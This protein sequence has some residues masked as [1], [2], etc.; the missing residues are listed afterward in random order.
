[1]IIWELLN[2]CRSFFVLFVRVP[3]DRTWSWWT[4][5]FSAG[6]RSGC[7]SAGGCADSA[8]NTGGHCVAASAAPALSANRTPRSTPPPL[9]QLLRGPSSSR[10]ERMNQTSGSGSLSSTT[11][12]NLVPT[13][14]REPT[15]LLLKQTGAW[16]T[17][18]AGT[19]ALTLV[20]VLV[21]VG[22]QYL[23]RYC[24]WK[25]CNITYLIYW[26]FVL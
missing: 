2:L 19:H 16:R 24:W 23:M 6:T 15:S 22:S 7:G 25:R 1:M 18:A 4:S 11:R 13:Y 12:L 9:H 3:T 26:V 17:G 8:S 10:Q 5:C 21:V 20:L 14:L